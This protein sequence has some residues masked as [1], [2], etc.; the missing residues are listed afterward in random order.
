MSSN[1]SQ[2]QG[3]SNQ[4]RNKHEAHGQGQRGDH[5]KDEANKKPGSGSGA[6][7]RETD[8]LEGRF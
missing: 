8:R 1:S 2:D 5:V 7:H 4:S 6:R 3:T